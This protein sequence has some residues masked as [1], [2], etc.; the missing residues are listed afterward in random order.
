LA[1]THEEIKDLLAE[2]EWDLLELESLW[3]ALLKARAAV[4]DHTAS[5]KHIQEQLLDWPWQ[6]VSVSELK[7]VLK[8]DQ[9]SDDGEVDGDELDEEG[10]NERTIL[11]TQRRERNVARE[12]QQD[13][14]Q[15]SEKTNH[16]NQ[17]APSEIAIRPRQPQSQTCQQ[18]TP[19]P[20]APPV[21][22]GPPGQQPSHRSCQSIVEHRNRALR[23]NMA[24]AWT[25]L[26][27]LILCTT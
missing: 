15:N 19:K 25:D 18:Q 13:R 20:P 7:S 23:D 21:T 3:E 1:I 27:L 14:Q 9:D 16:D 26:D 8:E 12:L 4:Y 2:W 5:A 24:W 17:G 6:C 10:T 11:T 22:E